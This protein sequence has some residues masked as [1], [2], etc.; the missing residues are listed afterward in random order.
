MI[1]TVIFD[2]GG[3]IVPLDFP[4]GYSLLA[5][6]TGAPVEDV[7]RRISATGLAARFECGEI[8]SED[9]YREFCAELGL[10][11]SFAEFRA[12]WSAIFL[13][14][15]NVPDSLL[16]ELKRSRRL[17]LLSNTNPLHFE[18]I[19]ETYAIL[20]HFDAFVLSYEVGVMK[21]GSR[22]YQE[23]IR[24]ARCLPEECF[25]TDDVAPYVE[26]ARREGMDAVQFTG[27]EALRREMA[28]RGLV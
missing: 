12:L 26:A 27:Y 8:S 24:Q 17:V 5:A 11:V 1:R 10:R 20:D 28:L 2:L 23:A 22:I 25:F 9:F 19:R 16:A 6:R 13:P 18:M 15:T 4:R 14:G 21:P 3:V 7:P